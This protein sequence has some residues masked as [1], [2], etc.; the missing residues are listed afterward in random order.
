MGGVHLFNTV[1]MKESGAPELL[2]PPRS[3]SHGVAPGRTWS[4]GSDS[5]LAPSAAAPTEAKLR[6]KRFWLF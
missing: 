3:V 5:T 6:R 4:N 2:T 1:G